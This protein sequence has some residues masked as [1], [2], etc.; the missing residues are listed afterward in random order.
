MDWKKY[1]KQ[2]VAKKKELNAKLYPPTAAVPPTTE[3]TPNADAES[4]EK[5]EKE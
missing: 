4:T 2:Q 5:A 3:S 1:K